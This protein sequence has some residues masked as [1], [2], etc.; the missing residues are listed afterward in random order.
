MGNPFIRFLNKF[1][2]PFIS[3]ECYHKIC[4]TGSQPGKAYGL[5]KVHKPGNPLRPVVSMI[6]TCEYGLA[7]YLVNI[8]NKCMPDEYMLN[9]TTDFIE[10]LQ[11]Y[12]LSPQD[13]LVS[14]DVVSLF[15]NIP[16]KKT[17]DL[18]CEYVYRNDNKPS[19][20]K[21]TF[22]EL[23]NIATGGLFMYNNSLYY[24]SDG[25]TMGSPLGPTL[26]N[27]FLAHFEH[28]FMH[29]RKQYNPELYLRYVDDVFCVFKSREMITEFH[30]FLNS[31]VEN[32]KFTY[33]IGPKKLAFLDTEITLPNDSNSDCTFTVYRKPTNTNVLLNFSAICPFPW[34]LSLMSCFVN[35]AYIVCNSWSLFDHE[36]NKLRTIFSKNGY[37]HEIFDKTVR[38][39]LDRKFDAQ[40]KKINILM[41]LI[42]IL[43]SLYHS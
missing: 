14:Y 6:G 39:F 16:L 35:R 28:Q 1:V 4:P 40:I 3:A 23:L 38:K 43:L 11:K 33:E 30:T 19:Y 13:I 25:V 2:K 42:C 22:K 32:L 17:I 18:V 8:I 15:T 10:K 41:N 9:S 20:P 37:P 36:I 26:A 7:Q 27:F 24:Q 34:K 12:P 29:T 31:L 5:C 21:S